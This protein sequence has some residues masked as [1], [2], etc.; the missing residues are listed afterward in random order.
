MIVFDIKCE[1]CNYVCNVIH[2]QHNFINWTSGSNDIDKFIQNSQLS[3]H[4][5]CEVSKALEW[6]P[7][8]MFNDIRYIEEGEFNN[9]YR[10]NW[11]DGFISKWDDD[12]QNWE[13]EKP[14]MFVILNNPASTITSELMNKV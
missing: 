13:R 10:A 5:N 4:S 2:F 8:N 6:I 1:K 14:N 11:I 7:Y 3:V 12:N 9:M